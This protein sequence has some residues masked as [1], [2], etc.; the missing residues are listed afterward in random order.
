MLIMKAPTSRFRVEGRAAVF[1]LGL[2]AQGSYKLLLQSIP[3]WVPLGFLEDKPQK[4][5]PTK[6]PNLQTLKPRTL[7][8]KPK[9]PEPQT[10]PPRYRLLRGCVGFA[11]GSE[12]SGV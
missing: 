9:V 11:G 6:P 4:L 10:P 12:S 5:K 8:P 3:T 1:R 7:N 2:R